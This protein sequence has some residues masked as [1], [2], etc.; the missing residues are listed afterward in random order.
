MPRVAA[1]FLKVKKTD[2]LS[3]SR[4]RLRRTRIARVL[5]KARRWKR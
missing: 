3:S 1:R 5:P 2:A 4:R